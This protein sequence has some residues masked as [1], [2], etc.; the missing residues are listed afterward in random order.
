LKIP[1]D[2]ITET[3]LELHW[4]ASPRWWQERSGEDSELRE[5]LSEPV[6]LAIRARRMGEDLYVEGDASGALGLTCGR[7]LT[8]YRAPIRER[9]RLVLE[10]AG[11]RVPADPEGAE[12]L[13]Q[14]GFC[15]SDELESGWFRGSEIRLDRFVQEVIALWFPAQPLCDENCRGLCPLC[16]VDRNRQDCDCQEAP[17][18]SPFAVLEA[19]R[20]KVT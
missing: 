4:I 11:A 13:A 5:S 3:P 17:V 19:L 16:G 2:R 20:E 6:D 15:L 14:D 18:A 8:R 10:P 7:C 12:S 1:V 9:F